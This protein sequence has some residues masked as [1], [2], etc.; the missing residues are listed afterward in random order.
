MYHCMS[1]TVAGQRLWDAVAKEVL[2]KMIWEVADFCGVEV[3][4]YCVMSNHFHVLVRVS[5]EQA[6]VDRTEILRRYRLLY[7]GR[8]IPGF[9]SGDEIAFD[10]S[11]SS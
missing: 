3:L 2:R 10:S 4:A 7:D 1:R 8:S 9:P 11:W 5:P 6:E